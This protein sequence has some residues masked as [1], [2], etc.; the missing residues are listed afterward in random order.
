[1]AEM[2]VQIPVAGA[3]ERGMLIIPKPNQAKTADEP[4]P[5]SGFLLELFLLISQRT[6][7]ASR[8]ACKR[9]GQSGYRGRK[10][11]LGNLQFLTLLF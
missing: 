10:K 9:S 3:K 6:E 8:N 2:R 4:R 7:H 1:M 11:P 5:D